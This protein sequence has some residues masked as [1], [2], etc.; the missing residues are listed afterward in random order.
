MSYKEDQGFWRKDPG[1]LPEDTQHY[2]QDIGIII[3][4]KTQ[5]SSSI[6]NI[7]MFISYENI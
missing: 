5:T 1:N 2:G 3:V 6:N 4:T 7:K